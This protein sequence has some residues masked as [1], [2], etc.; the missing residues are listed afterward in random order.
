MKIFG[1]KLVKVDEPPKRGNLKVECFLWVL[2]V[3]AAVLLVLGVYDF[4]AFRWFDA[5]NAK[6]ECF[7][8]FSYQHFE[9]LIALIAMAF[10]YLA[11]IVTAKVNETMNLHSFNLRYG[12]TQMLTAVR[13]IGDVERRWSDLRKAGAAPDAPPYDTPPEADVRTDKKNADCRICISNYDK[14]V[15]QN[16]RYKPWTKDEDSA[17]RIVKNY[18]SS[19]LEL[20]RSGG[21]SKKTLRVV[22]DTDAVTLLFNVIEPM[23][24]IINEKYKYDVF[25]DLMKVLRDV[26]VRKVKESGAHKKTG[27]FKN[28]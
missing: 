2:V 1:Y 12:D 27:H 14:F 22:C 4:A 6:E 9:I 7:V 26:Y 10:S 11:V 16:D 25:Y 8:R 13:T 24:A 21:I 3:F 5:S 17:R 19:A 20:Y 15:T 28:P 23:E 18:F